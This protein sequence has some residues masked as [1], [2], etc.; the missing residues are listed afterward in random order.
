[1]LDKILRD[2]GETLPKKIFNMNDS[3]L[4]AEPEMANF[5]WYEEQMRQKYSV[6]LQ[7]LIKCS[8][9]SKLN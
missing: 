7:V 1:M 9:K 2:T 5:Y 6:N 3:E 8:F 4:D